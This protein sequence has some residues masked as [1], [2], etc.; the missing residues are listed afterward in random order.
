MTPTTQDAGLIERLRS[1][2][3]L[4]L[5]TKLLLDEAA[6]RLEALSQAANAEPEV[7]R[8]IES[9][10]KGVAV[11]LYGILDPHPESVGLYYNLTAPVRAVGYWDEIDDT[12]CPVGS[13][14]LGPW[15]KPTHWMPLPASP[16][17]EER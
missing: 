1:A 6:D 9:A 17:V 13:T 5:A 12:W 16:T 15:F 4:H 2:D 8:G 10:P 11:L 14:W 3:H 7:W